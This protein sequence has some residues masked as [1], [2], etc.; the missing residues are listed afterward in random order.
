[1]QP[2]VQYARDGDIAIACWSI[3]SGEPL[4]ILSSP[5]FSHLELEWK[6]PEFRF[7]YQELAKHWQV[8]RYD[9]RGTGLSAREVCDVSIEAL[10]RDLDVVA[11]YF[12]LEEFV[13]F[14]QLSATPVAINYAAMNPERV[15]K[16]V[17][18][19][20]TVGIY[21][22][23]RSSKVEALLG[24]LESDW[25]LFVETTARMRR[26]WNAHVEAGELAELIKQSVQHDVLLR[27]MKGFET[28]DVRPC[29][30]E[31]RA[32][33][34]VLYA[35]ERID[36]D[37]RTKVLDVPSDLTSRIP[38]ASLKLVSADAAPPYAG[39]IAS[40]LKT[41]EAFLGAGR[42]NETAPRADDTVTGEPLSPRELDVLR[43]IAI[44]RSNKE[45]AE[46]LTISL[47]TVKTHASNIYRKL[48]V[49]SR[50][51]AARRL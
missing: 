27:M 12:H 16:L 23:S 33:T 39:D 35:E 32:P 7:W 47:T 14:G 18:A 24:L 51:Q 44:G 48:G 30:G 22:R 45:I 42:P 34:L 2:R 20:P 3:G 9:A 31:I 38:G 36:A 19:H 26:G 6:Q 25:D 10:S 1:M 40:V 37:K 49:R 29:L 28:F 21:D 11:S 17:L 5:P 13:L 50:V 8:I 41:I 46:D 15:S 43:Q 4:I